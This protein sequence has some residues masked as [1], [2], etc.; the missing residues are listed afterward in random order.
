MC[1]HIR[2][3]HTKASGAYVTFDFGIVWQAIAYAINLQLELL[4]NRLKE[5]IANLCKHITRYEWSVEFFH[6]KCIAGDCVSLLL[7][8]WAEFLCTFTL[9]HPV[10]QELSFLILLCQF[11]YCTFSQKVYV[12]SVV[13]YCALFQYNLLPSLQFQFFCILFVQMIC[14]MITGWWT[15][16]SSDTACPSYIR[17]EVSNTLLC[18]LCLTVISSGSWYQGWDRVSS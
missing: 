4:K 14:G 1:Y 17:K 8:W 18:Q 16:P 11:N 5:C 13:Y 2:G 9:H 15:H 6:R 12:I 3:V 7:K 10:L